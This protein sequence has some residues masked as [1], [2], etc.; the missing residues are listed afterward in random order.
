MLIDVSCDENGAV[1]TSHPTTFANPLFF[2][3]GV[4]HYCVDHTPSIY[5]RTAS[6]FISEQVKKL[7][8]PLV[9]CLYD[10]VLES[11]HIIEDGK[12]LSEESCR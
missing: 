5:Y 12:M 3:E 4:A 10:Q 11:G 7:V 6:A 8:E 1:E 9:C 2:E